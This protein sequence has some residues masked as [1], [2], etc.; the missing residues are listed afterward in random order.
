MPSR[1]PLS[2]PAPRRSLRVGIILGGNI[3][4]ERLI[5][6]PEPITIGQSAKATFCVPVEGLP[7]E[8]V[9]F[10]REQ[11]RY[12][13]Q[14][15]DAMDGRISDGTTVNTLDVLKAK[16]T[17]RRGDRYHMPL[18]EQSRGK[19]V[20]GAL[21][22]LFQFVA[23][24]PLQPRPRLPASVRGSITDR[25]EPQLAVILALSML[26][27]LGVAVYAHQM[28][29]TSRNR[30]DLLHREFIADQHERVIE[31][32]DEPVP[33][34][35]DSAGGETRATE[36]ERKKTTRTVSE[37]PKEKAGGDQAPSDADIQEQIKASAFVKLATAGG[38]EQGRYGEMAYTDQGADL[39]KS[40]ENVKRQGG[41]VAALGREGDRGLRGPRSGE[42]G[43]ESGE[44]RI[45]GPDTGLNAGDKGEEEIQSLAKYDVIDVG[46][47]A[48]LDPEDVAKRIRSKYLAGIKRCH[49]RA[50][51][52]NPSAQGRIN[53]AFTI[54][55]SGRVTDSNVDGFDPT[56]DACIKGLTAGWLFGIPKDEGGK[57]TTASFRIPLVLKPGS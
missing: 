40:L 44:G 30:T 20:F 33:A 11:N 48:T 21:T 22:V 17:H 32:F 53:I 38:S 54:G 29:L 27:H 39:N 10:A 2:N 55:P 42:L 56:V 51:K 25:I 57:P 23:A 47:E 18:T 16:G 7:K 6:N 14:F 31:T 12:V 35:T 24:P 50:L 34:D 3:V 4:E 15:S 1:R 9:L 8:W 43:V 37:T 45:G 52:L 46:A 13:L 36:P 49:Q 19:I 41:G 26:L 28:E 5:R